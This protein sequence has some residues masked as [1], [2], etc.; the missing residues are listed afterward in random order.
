MKR[1]G[2]SL[3]EMSIVLLIMA[4]VLSSLL[5]TITEGTKIKASETTIKHLEAIESALKA[6]YMSNVALP[7][8][9]PINAAVNTSGFGVE[10]SGA[11]CQAGAAATRYGVAGNVVGGGVPTK[12]LGLA[13]EYAFDGW[14]RRIAYHVDHQAT[15]TATFASA[16]G[17]T[18]NG[19]T[20]V[21]TT[22]GVYA[23]ISSGRNGHG[24]YTRGGTPFNSGSTNA[25]ELENCQRGSAPC[26][27]AYNATFVQKMEQSDDVADPTDRFDDILIYKLAGHLTGAGGGAGGSSFWEDAGGNNIR[28][29]NSG[30]VGI[31][32][33]APSEKLHVTGGN[34]AAS[35]ATG[36]SIVSTNTSF[37]G[38]VAQFYL[39]NTGP[40][41]TNWAINA[42]NTATGW[43]GAR[44]GIAEG[45][46]Y[47]MVIEQGG[48]VGIG[49]TDPTSPLEVY[50]PSDAARINGPA[51]ATNPYLS[52]ASN[53]VRQGYIGWGVPN[54]N[55]YVTSDFALS[56]GAGSA[57]RVRITS[58]GNVGIGTTNPSAGKL[59]VESSVGGGVNGINSTS[60]SGGG[61]GV[62]G[63]VSGAGATGN[64]V[65]G[66]AQGGSGG[67][68]VW[69]RAAGTGMGVLGEN[70]AA[71]G[72]SVG[73]RGRSATSHGIMGDVSS[74]SA[75]YYGVLGQNGGNWGALGRSDG[76]AFVGIGHVWASGNGY[77]AGNTYPSDE[78]LKE[79]IIEIKGS[80]DKLMALHP[81][82]YTWKMKSEQARA[83][84]LGMQTGLIAQEVE[85]IAPE[86]VTSVKASKMPALDVPP[87]IGLD[88]KAIPPV[89]HI[90]TLNEELG[91]TKGVD[92]GKLV[93]Y[94]IDAVQ[95]LNEK[96]EAVADGKSVDKVRPAKPST[97]SKDADPLP[98][99]LLAVL[100][101]QTLAI[102]ALAVRGRRR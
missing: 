51:A 36:S 35:N 75:S 90:P 2:F 56:L 38:G 79:N 60:T 73:V 57:E 69:G 91:E 98:H 65:T 23:L 77:F 41:G 62:R 4:T 18:V 76:Y 80:L 26:A 100:A 101:A 22:T 61:S 15:E 72:G 21:R 5:P 6:Y 12:T 31:G 88:G 83:V 67:T 52:I 71:A 39:G 55:M 29:S 9:A 93:P 92:Y 44:L 17:I 24:G 81:V 94:L 25:H 50:G 59:Q 19:A 64:G 102:A 70:T 89:K 8:P 85:K 11:N 1:N 28:N 99:W 40:G 27:G 7:C 97:A 63:V 13:D 74:G 68:G 95:E 42:G 66:D 96:V 82:H 86:L 45:S 78:R 34:I 37:N 20:G 16:G 10:D 84:G 3:V 53:N 14:G 48:N 49:T 58:S 47:R 43:L 33:L 46:T 87:S 32:T 54:T 30:N